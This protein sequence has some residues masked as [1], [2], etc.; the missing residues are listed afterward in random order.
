MQ[1]DA[2]ANLF[3]RNHKLVSFD[4]IKPSFGSFVV[5]KAMLLKKD[6]RKLKWSI[7]VSMD[8]LSPMLCLHVLRFHEANGQADILD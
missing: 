3:T 7:K 1:T 8:W 2:T 6:W 5:E 4:G